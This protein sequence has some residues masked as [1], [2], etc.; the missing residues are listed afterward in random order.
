MREVMHYQ[1]PIIRKPSDALAPTSEVMN[2]VLWRQHPLG[3]VLL[4]EGRKLQ[5][6]TNRMKKFIERF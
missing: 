5:P 4:I 6:P 1:W 3:E 2:Q